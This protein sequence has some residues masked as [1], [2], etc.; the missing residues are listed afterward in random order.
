[1]R[2]ALIKSDNS[3]DRFASNID[4]NV[5][6]KPGFRWLTCPNVARPTFDATTEAVDGPSYNVDANAVTESW[7]KRSLTTQ[8]LS[9][10]KDARLSA[11]DSLQFAIAFDI[12][13]RVRVLEGKAAITQAQY[14]AALKARL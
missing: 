12:E 8:G 6:T 14:R 10:R 2:Y 11:V 9:D 7:T 4:P 1:M 3:I 13:N 5:Q